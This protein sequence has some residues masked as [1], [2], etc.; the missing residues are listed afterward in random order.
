M[1]GSEVPAIR[2]VDVVVEH[3]V[4]GG[5]P[6]RAVDHVTLDVPAATSLALVGRS[7]SGKSSLVAVMGLMRTPT[8]GTVMVGGVTGGMGARPTRVRASVVGMVFQS[9]HLDPHLTAVENCMMAWYLGG[10]GRRVAA[11]ARAAELVDLVGIGHLAGRRVADMSGGERQRVAIARALYTAPQV[12]IADE[13]TGN[14]DE[15]T[16]EV[17]RTLLYGLPAAMGTTVVVVTHD[18]AVAAGA[19][20]VLT[21]AR[22]RLLEAVAP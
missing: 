14:L 2:L 10:V 18:R 13:P 15:D 7:G 12:L 8:S 16:S 4:P 21:L 11:R 6:V 3:P 19:D 22:G 1:S 17:V 9:F 20:R 5:S